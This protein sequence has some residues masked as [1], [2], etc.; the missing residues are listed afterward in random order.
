MADKHVIVI[1]Q[2]RGDD[3]P[4]TTIECGWGDEPA[5]P[6][7]QIDCPTC[8]EY[9]TAACLDEHGASVDPGCGVRQ[10]MEDCGLEA[11]GVE[12]LE[13]RVAVKSV[14]YD[15]GWWLTAVPWA[16]IKESLAKGERV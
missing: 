8:L 3:F 1:R 12:G 13:V 16:E 7:K 11:I 6:C 2:D 9:S 10:W 4:V 15:E 14:V 5:R